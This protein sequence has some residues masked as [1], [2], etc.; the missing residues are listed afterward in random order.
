MRLGAIE[1]ISSG[2][3]S[4]AAFSERSEDTPR[5]Q[6]VKIHN[7]GALIWRRKA[8]IAYFALAGALLTGVAAFVL[9]P[10]YTA[11]SQFVIEPTQAEIAAGVLDAVVDTHIATITSD[12]RLR[13]VLA[14]LSGLP[15]YEATAPSGSTGA[16]PAFE[17]RLR[18]GLLDAAGLLEAAVST[19]PADQAQSDH[20]TGL[21][22]PSLDEAKLSLMV[23]QERRSS[24]VSISYKSSNP[25]R[26]AL[27]A[28][29]ITAFHLNALSQRKQLERE[30]SKQWLDQNLAQA[31]LESDAADEALRAY[32]S[33]HGASLPDGAK[34]EPVAEIVQQLEGV[35][36][37]LARKEA[38]LEHIRDLRRAEADVGTRIATL[39]SP[40]RTA[41]PAVSDVPNTAATAPGNTSTPRP[42]VT[43]EAEVERLERDIRVLRIQARSL[44]EHTTSL[45]TVSGIILAQRKEFQ[46]LE[47]RAASA[48]DSVRELSRLKREYKDPPATGVQ[49]LARASVPL[50]PSSLSPYLYI[51][52]AVIAF[53]VLGGVAASTRE[54]L[55]R[56]FRQPRDIESVLGVPCIGLIPDAGRSAKRPRRP[57]LDTSA[58]PNA[59]AIETV[60][61]MVQAVTGH[62]KDSGKIILLTSSHPAEGTTALAEGLAS[63]L[64]SFQQRVL[65]VS[66]DAP[67][68][69]IHPTPAGEAPTGLAGG[70][71]TPQYSGDA[72]LDCDR[73]SVMELTNGDPTLL[74]GAALITGLKVVQERYDY[75]VMD[76]PAVFVSPAIPALA[77]M[78]DAV[79]FAVRWGSTTRDVAANALALLS[80]PATVGREPPPNV[81]AVLTRVDLKSYVRYRPGDAAEFLF[82]HRTRLASNSLP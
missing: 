5:N 70:S 18:G 65:L 25:V 62:R 63:C 39:A 74:V 59:F 30:N 71:A 34:G 24:V 54:Q 58:Y 81:L 4:G 50:R 55:D 3:S 57:T 46:T 67:Q 75:I 2:R 53:A 35:R 21:A 26:A 38:K 43:R 8:F 61:A 36:A 79:L 19:P 48:A 51:P 73:L 20:P 40:S 12:A 37:E 78:A 13:A 14:S 45:Q 49:L 17:D 31:Q 9:P 60:C 66:A 27:I 10:K 1:F 29:Q 52:A 69:R 64:Q 56:T 47:R 16:E 76:A 33:V 42:D 23:R 32:S 15:E 44:A 77:S 41:E 28:N 7:I 80:R 6:D 68:E 22:P 82:D 72:D 11:T